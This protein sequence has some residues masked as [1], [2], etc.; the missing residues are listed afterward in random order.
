MLFPAILGPVITF[1][2]FFS[3]SSTKLPTYI[4]PAMFPLAFITGYIFEEYIENNKFSFQIKISSV[5]LT[6]I[7]A[8]AGLSAAGIL[9]LNYLG[10]NIGFE[11]TIELK[12]L[13]ISAGCLLI[14]YSLVNIV[15]LAKNL[16]LRYFYKSSIIFMVILTFIT[17]LLIFNLIVS[18]G[19]NE[20]IE[21]SKYAKQNERKLA[22]FDFGHRYSVI[23]Y[24]GNHVD[25]M[26]EPDYKWLEEKL[27]N[28]Y[29]VILKNK[30]M[31][32][33]PEE[34]KFEVLKSGKKYSLVS[35]YYDKNE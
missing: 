14:I 23:Y 11:M 13:F 21:Y 10:K 24:Y 31:I 22:T 17:N 18:F 3:I 34:Y 20:L 15:V 25:I 28:D 8:L 5:I 33:M 32:T 16:S 6:I 26:E 19:Q 27:A 4:L 2:L 29:Y 1:T 12:R 7:F 9:V 35:K 30:N